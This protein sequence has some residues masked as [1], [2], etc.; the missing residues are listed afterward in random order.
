MKAMNS[1]CQQDRLAAHE[2]KHKIQ[3][4]IDQATLARLFAQGHLCAAQINCLNLSS[5]QAVWQ[6]CL[7][8]CGH[9]V[10]VQGARDGEPKAESSLWQHLPP[11]V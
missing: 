7:Q 6:L 5:K 11:I 9:C 1:Q 10:E 4:E 3:L 2:S 8:A